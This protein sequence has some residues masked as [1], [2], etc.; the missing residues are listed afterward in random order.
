[1]EY[2]LLEMQWRRAIEQ[3]YIQMTLFLS[4]FTLAGALVYKVEPSL[5]LGFG[6]FYHIIQRGMVLTA[7]SLLQSYLDT[8]FKK[9]L[10]SL[11]VSGQ[12][13][14]LTFSCDSKFPLTY[15]QAW[16]LILIA[17]AIT[18]AF[19]AQLSRRYFI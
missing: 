13:A 8:P 1:M 9:K 17:T 10:I 12:L 5:S 14:Y 2:P 4:S 19:R 18:S 16:I 15:S 3:D 7:S 11:I 6:C